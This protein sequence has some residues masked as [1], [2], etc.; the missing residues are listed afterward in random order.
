MLGS[1]NGVGGPAGFSSFR[2][3]LTQGVSFLKRRF[4]SDDLANQES[5][6]DFA[7]PQNVAHLHNNN[8]YQQQQSAAV[9]QQQQR[10]GAPAKARQQSL[11]GGPNRPQSTTPNQPPPS[12]Q[13]FNLQGLGQPAKNT[14]ISAPTSPAKSQG[15]AA[16]V[17]GLTRNI[18]QAASSQSQ[19]I[20]GN[21]SSSMITSSSSTNYNRDR[22]K[23][24]LIVDDSHV[25]W[26]KYFKNRKVLGD[27]DLR[28]EQT[29]FRHISVISS[30]TDGCLVY[31]EGGK[32]FKPDFTFV[33]QSA[34]NCED[35]FRNII[36]GLLYGGVPGL[37]SMQSI[38]NFAD[39]P[40]VFAHLLMLYRRL[41]PEKFPLIDQVY[42]V[43]RDKISIAAS[44]KANFPLIVKSGHA[45]AGVG[46]IKVNNPIDLSDVESLLALHTEYATV[47]SYVDAKYDIHVQ[48]IGPHYKAFMRKGIS[49]SWKSSRGSAM[50]EQ[51]A[52][53][54]KYR[55]WV[56]EVSQLFGG[57]DVC[58]V[59][60]LVAK[61]GREII[62]EVNDC[63]FPFLGETQE[64]DRRAVAELVLQKMNHILGIKMALQQ[65]E[66]SG[67]AALQNF[68][69]HES[70]ISQTVGGPRQPVHQPTV[71]QPQLQPNQAAMVP[72]QVQSPPANVAS[73]PPPP[74]G[75]PP[76]PRPRPPP[77][78]RQG[79]TT[80]QGSA[81]GTAVNQSLQHQV[82]EQVDD[83][84]SNLK[85]TFAGIFG[86]M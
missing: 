49:N 51:V 86:D 36:V 62:Y 52:V 37:N 81:A 13:D 44:F 1:S 27:W 15:A 3:S 56:D 38:F 16:V 21:I 5:N 68:I 65:K 67:P 17:Q 46:K 45:H 50:L 54:E 77:P 2:D 69:K 19:K 61:D 39:K 8:H 6:P 4:S 85:K 41:G 7:P 64:E 32:I 14:T 70:P 28:V 55:F 25:D 74:P 26:L 40:W 83:T 10:P 9:G 57:M 34:R 35:D 30:A 22:C 43:G 20:A 24:L 73:P 11:T 71:P 75:G 80:S 53:T 78:G 47:E 60:A 72:E 29:D 79:S 63:T 84:M 33:R 82:K 23:C 59:A 48:K 42:T 31:V 12:R 18:L 66:G 58:S 76:P